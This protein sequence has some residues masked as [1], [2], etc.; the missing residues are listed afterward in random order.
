VIRYP[1]HTSFEDVTF[2]SFKGKTIPF[3]HEDPLANCSSREE[4]QDT[5]MLMGALSRED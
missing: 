5:V 1:G 2:F 4:F 3:T